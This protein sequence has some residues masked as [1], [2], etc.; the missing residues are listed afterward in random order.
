MKDEPCKKQ[1]VSRRDFLSLATIGTV[2]LSSLAAFAGM[3]RLTKPNVYYEESKK[4]KI[5]M[6]ENF[7]IGTVKK[8][9][10]SNFFVFADN[11]GLHAVSRVC[12]HLGCLVALTDEG[13]Q[14]PCHGSAYNKDGK[15]IAG[16][17]PRSLPWLKISQNIDGTLVVDAGKEIK[18]GTIFTV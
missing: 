5:G 2:V 3:L 18:T 17:A 12:T 6:P 10:N 7:P 14:C 15:V 8:F 16:P 11:E 9:D 4:V 1:G 13:F